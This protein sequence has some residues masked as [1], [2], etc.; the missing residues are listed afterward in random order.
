MITIQQARNLVEQTRAINPESRSQFFNDAPT[1]I[2]SLCQQLEARGAADMAAA[3]G[4]AENVVA[5]LQ[6]FAEVNSAVQNL[7]AEQ[8]DLL[9]KGIREVVFSAVSRRARA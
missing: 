9:R 4:A 7:S 8:R 6:H 2:E 1:V 3:T 5:R